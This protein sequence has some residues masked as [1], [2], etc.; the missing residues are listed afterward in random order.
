M[1]LDHKLHFQLNVTLGHSS[2][3]ADVIL[4]SGEPGSHDSRGPESSK[5]GKET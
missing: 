1:E 4:H 5:T 2:L 3:I